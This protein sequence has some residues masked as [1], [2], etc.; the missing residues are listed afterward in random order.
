MDEALW[1]LGRG[2]G[3]VGLVLFTLAVVLGIVVRGGRA[4]VGLPRF[5]I[6]RLHRDVALMATVFIGIHIVSLLFDSYAQLNLVDL[7]VPFL[8]TYRPFW[9][10]LGTVAV[11]LVIAVIAT[12]LLRHRIGSRAFRVVHFGTYLLWPISLAHAIGAGTD[13][14]QAWFIALAGVCASAVGVAVAWRL[15]PRFRRTGT[16]YAGASETSPVARRRLETVR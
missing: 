14:T 13:G 8:A 5:G 12:A 7:L 2:T 6:A 11:D 3:V 16:A 9:L 4:A 10:G 15:S 1:A